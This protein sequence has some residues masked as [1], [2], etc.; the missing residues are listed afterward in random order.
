MYSCRRRPHG[1][2]LTDFVTQRLWK[3]PAYRAAQAE[4]STEEPRS[5]QSFAQNPAVQTL[6]PWAF[7]L[8]AHRGAADVHQL[9][10]LHTRWASGF[11]APACQ[12]PVQVQLRL[13]GGRDTFE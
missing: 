12:T 4:C 13:A 11:T 3:R 10:V 5:G 9:P 2:S 7:Y 1:S 6:A 8:F